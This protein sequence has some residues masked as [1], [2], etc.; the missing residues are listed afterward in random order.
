MPS[1]PGGGMSCGPQTPGMPTG[2]P[3]SANTPGLGPQPGPGG[4][5]PPG[6][7]TGLPGGPGGMPGGPVPSGPQGQMSDFTQQQSHIF[8]FS[9]GLANKASEMVLG[10]QTKSIITFHLDQ[11]ST[12]QFLQV[13]A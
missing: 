8:V 7:A 3:P 4:P 11:P 9:T 6:G 12:Q 13:C 2:M 10:N 1:T 5:M